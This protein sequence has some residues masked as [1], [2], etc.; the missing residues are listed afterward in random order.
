MVLELF[1]KHMLSQN[2]L[3]VSFNKAVR[4]LQT[5]PALENLAVLYCL[6][7][8]TSTPYPLWN[9]GHQLYTVAFL[10]IEKLIFGKLCPWSNAK[11]CL[12]SKVPGCC[13]VQVP[14]CSSSWLFHCPVEWS[15]PDWSFLC[16]QQQCACLP[17][18]SSA[19]RL[20]I[21]VL[22]RGPSN[23]L[24]SYCQDHS[25]PECWIHDWHHRCFWVVA[26]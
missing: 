2:G 22:Q 17:V 6:L 11:H 25:E 1:R 18:F 8:S 13:G 3:L 7:P 16:S 5:L 20:S 9:W 10:Y 14:I 23:F 12:P 24:L 15:D 26:F 4:F 21:R 19:L